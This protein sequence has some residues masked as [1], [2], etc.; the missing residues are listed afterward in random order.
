LALK[1]GKIGDCGWHRS[2]KTSRESA[3]AIKMQVSARIFIVFALAL[4]SLALSEAVSVVG[5][6]LDDATNSS[7]YVTTTHIE[8]STTVTPFSTAV[9]PTTTAGPYVPYV[10]PEGPEE[11][12]TMVPVV[13]IGFAVAL[14]GLFLIYWHACRPRLP[15][16]ED[17]IA[18]SSHRVQLMTQ[19]V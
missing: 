14:V 9:L 12:K 17:E 5:A 2:R 13:V 16:L 19:A 8:T 3:K 11:Y 15:R 1:A 4:H 7:T 18:V 10:A 6:V